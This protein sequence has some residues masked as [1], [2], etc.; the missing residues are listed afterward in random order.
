MSTQRL[1]SVFTS[2]MS[3][4]ELESSSSS[5]IIPTITDSEDY[6]QALEEEIKN[7]ERSLNTDESIGELICSTSDENE[8]VRNESDQKLMS[9]LT[10]QKTK[11]DEEMKNKLIE[12]KEMIINYCFAKSNKRQLTTV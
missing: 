11:F 2:K 5:E 10:S 8:R 3:S 12:N 6:N 4:Q 1:Q 7:Y 9:K